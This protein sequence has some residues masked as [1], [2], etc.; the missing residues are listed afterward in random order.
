L[1]KNILI[2][3]P[4]PNFSFNNSNWFIYKITNKYH[5]DQII[6]INENNNLKKIN[7]E[8][9]ILSFKGKNLGQYKVI[10]KEINCYYLKKI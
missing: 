3:H 5:D 6:L 2:L 10:E 7:S 8:K 1:E 4:N 9:Y